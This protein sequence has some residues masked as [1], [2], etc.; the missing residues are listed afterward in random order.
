MVQVEALD[1]NSKT[2]DT[3][4]AGDD[5]VDTTKSRDELLS[6]LRLL[7][8]RVSTQNTSPFRWSIRPLFDM[9]SRMS[10]QMELHIEHVAPSVS[11]WVQPVMKNWPEACMVAVAAIRA[12]PR[13]V[14][15]LLFMPVHC[16]ALCME[17]IRRQAC[18][19]VDGPADSNS[20]GN[21]QVDTLQEQSG[22]API[23]ALPVGA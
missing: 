17:S 16:I 5:D 21:N 11:A 20:S 9:A 2:T 23:R 13:F 6:E 10:T 8:M 19:L 1:R 3:Q 15:L 4:E 12:Y 18:R 22:D 7:R 14:W